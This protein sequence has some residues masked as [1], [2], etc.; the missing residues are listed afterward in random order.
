MPVHF[1]SSLRRNPR[2][3]RPAANL[4]R[5]QKLCGFFEPFF[6][7]FIDSET[8]LQTEGNLIVPSRL[9]RLLLFLF[10][11]IFLSAGWA[12]K[13]TGTL[14]GQVMDPSGAIIP[15]ASVT[16]SG[17][18]KSMTTT[19]RGDGNY[20]F[21]AVPPGQYTIHTSIDGFTPYEMQGVSISPGKTS[22]LNIPMTLAVQ[23]QEVHVQAEGNTID[24]TP[25][26]NANALVM[27]GK[28]LDALSDDP[29]ELASEIQALAGPGAGPNGA[30]I[31]IDGF[32]GGEIPPKSS[33]RE[34]RVNQNPF[35]AEYDRLGYGRIEILT[36]PGSEKF[37]GH[38]FSRGNYSGFNAQNPIL[39]ANLAPG[40]KLIQ[41]PSY[42]SYFAHAN[43]GGPIKPGSSYFVSGFYRDTQN[44]EVVNA[45]NPAT[46]TATHPNGL[47]LNQAISNPMSRTDVNPRFDFQ[48]GKSNTLTLRY[49]LYRVVA[50]NDGVGQLALPEQAYNLHNEENQ[51]QA[52]D[53][54]VLSRNFV[55]NIRFQYR[56]IRN[57]QIAQFTSPTV[58]VQGSFTD[59]GSNAGTQRDSQDDFELQD[60]LTGQKGAHTLNFGTRLRV[61]DD[62]NYTNAGTNGS[63]VFQSNANYVAKT[64]QQYSVTVVNKYTARA[65]LFDAALFYQ[66]DWKINPR[67]TFS[68]G[69]RW[70]SQNYIHDKNDW[71][72]RVYLAYALGHGHRPKTVVRAGYG[73]FY[74]RFTVPNGS[75]GAPYILQT[76]HNNLPANPNTPSNQQIFTVTNPAGYTETNPGNAIKPPNPTSSS[77]APTYWT[78][79]PKFH[80]AVD[81]QAAV[82]IDRQIAKNLTGNVTYLY[83]RGVHQYLS[84]NVTAPFFNGAANV[85]P[86]APLAPPA[87]NIYQFQSG[88]VYRQDQIIATIK[89]SLH[90]LSLFSFYTYSNA[91]GDTSSVFHFASN[92]SDPGQ[93]YG[94]TAFDIHNRFLLLA[95]Y[96]GPHA[97][98]V[99]PMF[100][101]NSGIPYNVKIGSDLTANNQFN[102]R[103]TFANPA[104]GCA[105]PLVKFE[106]YCL[107][108]NPI[109]TK[110]PIV[111]YGLGTGPSNYSLNMRVSKV[112]G[113]GPR[114]GRPGFGGPGGFQHGGPGLGGR[115]LSGNAG[116]P[117]RMDASVP[118][119]YSVTL[120]A[121]GENI[122]NHEN[123]GVP[124]GT[125]DSTR[126]FGKS[127]SL[128]RGFFNSHTAG[129]RSIFL[130]TAINF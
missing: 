93:D 16:L 84:N 2:S 103:P 32:S 126:F 35:S 85:Y 87:T 61:Y 82:G 30:Q 68:Y 42:Y 101:Y 13:A 58:S 107:N 89:A 29:D 48:L 49:S 43:V 100:V 109:G 97:F 75:Y 8:L 27:K 102:A 36:K 41:E 26:S 21:N 114:L 24:T 7:L 59:G 1:A 120:S 46:I 112:F 54:M 80:A 123:L 67:F 33:I 31:Y 128:A 70:E 18:G 60:Y 92:A 96:N 52:S 108:P 63:Y 73:W 64:P 10:L 105:A 118:R 81:M 12:Q 40:Q 65:V 119:K 44:V 9:V 91:L 51:I 25:E 37:H 15:G 117:G 95:S 72:P 50:T 130:Q 122:L 71:A 55:D 86:T 53:S 14:R 94:R 20:Q 19:S 3:E 124:N 83:S 69:V 78:L 28:D 57:N 111:P 88:G 116:G 6:V 47:T 5:P 17:N 39:N 106:G 38:V 90:R 129:N 23:Q 74:E 11:P 127:Q 98:T 110:E 125:L 4:S 99:S 113:F 66:D 56:H 115:G 62:A 34:I 104:N 79:D 45:T 76:I 121:F 22:T 77:S